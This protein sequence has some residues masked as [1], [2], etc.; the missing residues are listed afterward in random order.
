MKKIILTLLVIVTHFF[1][2]DGYGALGAG[3]II[4]GK[5][6]D[7]AMAKE[8]L[9]ISYNKIK[10]DYEFIN[11]S[12]KDITET[13]VFPLPEFQIGV[14]IFSDHVPYLKLI[15]SFKV[16][17]D[18]KPIAFQTK[19]RT[20]A[21]RGEFEGQ[22]I[23]EKLLKLGFSERDIIASEDKYNEIIEPKMKILQANGLSV[24]AREEDDYVP[25]TNYITYE[26]K[27]TF[28]AHQKVKISHEYQPLTGGGASW[29]Y[30]CHSSMPASEDDEFSRYYCMS[31]ETFKLLDN[32]C[33]QYFGSPDAKDYYPESYL[34]G[35]DVSY[36]LKTAN[37]WKDGIRD[38]TLIIHKKPREVV[39]FCF[40]VPLR[41]INPFR[42]EV[43]LENFKPEQD[44][45]IFFVN[46]FW[47]DYK[48]L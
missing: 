16:V 48:S 36:I 13:I 11:E 43:H 5:T 29:R 18:G 44:L 27:Q 3:G 46:V 15:D 37:T 8:V 19:V 42:D 35:V 20:V 33:F 4:I 31:K 22:D 45:N 47:E 32:Y 6:D 39:S 26:W 10:V 23:T 12:D 2:N 1:A 28:K 25:W 40:P 9:E 21:N 14:G 24:D 41:H 38:F 7:I 17:V 34:I 30:Y